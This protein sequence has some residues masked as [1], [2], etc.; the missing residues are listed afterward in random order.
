MHGA[1][2][3]LQSQV[4]CSHHWAFYRASILWRS[5]RF[6]TL[7]LGGSI[8][9]VTM[10]HAIGTCHSSRCFPSLFVFP[11][12]LQFIRWCQRSVVALIYVITDIIFRPE[13]WDSI[14]SFFPIDRYVHLPASESKEE[15]LDHD[16]ETPTPK[17]WSTSH[18]LV[19][20][21]V[22][23]AFSGGVGFV[24]GMVGLRSPQRDLMSKLQP[25]IAIARFK[26]EKFLTI[27]PHSSSRRG[28]ISHDL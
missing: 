16:V 20:L 17:M 15:M 1:S 3:P 25:N 2:Q 11:L 26:G 10:L 22:T 14:M 4:I 6:L 18:V 7:L 21:L 23:M 24:I 13:A 19:M 27:Y 5:N 9:F 8:C 28:Q 12:L